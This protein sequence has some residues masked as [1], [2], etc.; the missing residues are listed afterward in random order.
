V[1]FGQTVVKQGRPQDSAALNDRF[2]RVR[3]ES[4]AD[5]FALFARFE[6]KLS[7]MRQPRTIGRR[8]RQRIGAA[9]ILR[10]LEAMLVVLDK[11]HVPAVW[12][13]RSHRARRASWRLGRAVLTRRR[14]EGPRAQHDL[15]AT[16]DCPRRRLAN[17]QNEIC[18]YTNGQHRGRRAVVP[19]YLPET[20]K[21]RA[22]ADCRADRRRAG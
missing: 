22:S 1:T 2:W 11:T 14:R 12:Q 15:D 10:R 3:R 6:S 7:N 20:S 19:I 21:P 5:S 17:C 9:S 13:R 18:I 8:A 16:S 4:A